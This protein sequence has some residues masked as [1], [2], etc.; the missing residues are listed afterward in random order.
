MA[1]LKDKGTDV[2]GMND[3][4]SDSASAGTSSRTSKRSVLPRLVAPDRFFRLLWNRYRGTSWLTTLWRLYDGQHVSL[5]LSAVTFVIKA[6][7]LWAWPLITRNVVNALSPVTPDSA[8]VVQTNIVIML[9]LIVQNVP[10]HTLHVY[11]LSK[12]SRNMQ[13]QLR[14]VLVTRLQQL[15][16]SFHSNFTSGRLQ[17]KILRD[18]EV[19]DTLSRQLIG[20]VLNGA[21]TIAFAM[22]VTLLDNPKLSLFFFFTC[23]VAVALLQGFRRPLAKRNT[24]F[25]SEMETMTSMVSEMMEMIPVTRAHGAEHVETRRLKDQFHRLRQEGLR[26]DVINAVF[27]ASSW[28]S[29]QLLSLGCIGTTAYLALHGTMR[30]G[31]IVMYV[32]F[33]G[34]L[35]GSVNAL[36]DFYPTLCL[37]RESIRSL[38]EILECPDLERNEGRRQVLSVKGGIVVDHV[39]YRYAPEFQPAIRDLT[40]QIQPGETAAFVGESGSGKS[41]LM[42]LVIGFRRPTSGRI[43]LDDEDMETLDMRSYRRFLAVVSQNTILFSGTLRE[44]ITYGL[45]RVDE[46]QLHDVLEM[47]NV[48]QFL[49]D[50]PEG[51][52]T[53]I[54]EHGGKLSGGQR[55][56]ISI[57]RALIRHPQVIVLDEATSALDV[58]SERL[59]QEAI[60]RLIRGRTTLIVAHRLST[61]R[62]ADR[63]VV[64]KQGQIAE[65]G[66]HAELM[67]RQ[68]EFS[69]MVH[70]QS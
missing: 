44:N 60:Q 52:N 63:V 49:K 61:I 11:F 32:G 58:I 17:S 56:R 64:M 41:T 10:F 7:P 38:S 67:A 68:G 1:K 39:T 26:L 69:R 30:P 24:Q 15:S 6:S 50:L 28:S 42:N 8:S 46:K 22:G 19:I 21:V 4:R 34:M 29:F 16:I 66:T 14:N 12:V 43:L 48:T 45:E 5:A 65:L 53:R 25:R 36:V 27:G 9:L 70:L 33:F 13:L 31:D 37:G 47:A 59:V 3:E 40:L 57:A 51:L 18:V 62:N 54:G 35:V 23:P 20:V 2:A 55:Q